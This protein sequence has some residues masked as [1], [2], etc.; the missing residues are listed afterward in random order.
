MLAMFGGQ[1]DNAEIKQN[2]IISVNVHKKIKCVDSNGYYIVKCLLINR[3]LVSFMKTL[4]HISIRNSAV[5]LRIYKW[6]IL[7][8]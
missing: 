8:L 2:S 5:T 7:I 3:L 1:E 6:S 4:L